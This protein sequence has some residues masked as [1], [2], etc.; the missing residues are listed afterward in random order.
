MSTP[1]VKICGI[2]RAEDA[3]AAVALGA[4][5]I[6]FVFWPASPR[7]LDPYRARRI[8]ARLPAFV[9]PVGVFVNQPL[10]YMNAVASLVG[11][12]AI[13][14]HGD[15]T[16][17]VAIGLKRPAIKAL[18]GRTVIADAEG[19]PESTVLLVDAHDP[20][21]RGGTG[22]TANWTDA[23]Q[24]ARRRRVL[25]SG[26][27]HAGN[28]AAAVAA[29]RPFGVDVSSGVEATPGVKDHDKLAAFFAQLRGSAAN[30]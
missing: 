2:T 23:A 28:I 11:L 15:E 18:S 24:L 29:V 1:L 7:F 20:V 8:A 6:G 14:L 22:R 25:L 9:T 26:G 12:G 27:L 4:S 16:P 10:D 13:Q 5:A 30:A 3:T 17:D 21:Q 19:W